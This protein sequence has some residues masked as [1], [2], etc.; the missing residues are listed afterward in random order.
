MLALLGPYVSE[1]REYPK[2]IRKAFETTSLV[3]RSTSLGKIMN[4]CWRKLIYLMA[5]KHFFHKIFIALR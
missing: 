2:E 4:M 5:G 3:I 1:R